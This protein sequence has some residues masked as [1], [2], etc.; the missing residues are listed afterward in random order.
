MLYTGRLSLDVLT[1]FDMTLGCL[2]AKVTLAVG[3]LDVGVHGTSLYQAH[4]GAFL[5]IV[6]LICKIIIA[7]LR[8][9]RSVVPRLRMATAE[10]PLTSVSVGGSAPSL[11]FLSSR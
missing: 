1:H 6:T 2:F 7:P 11:N 4:L 3:T 9:R 8:G 5:R 10:R